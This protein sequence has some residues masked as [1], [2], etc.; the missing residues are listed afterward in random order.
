MM[1]RDCTAQVN[2]RSAGCITIVHWV[3]H[4]DAAYRKTCT[5]LET[6]AASSVPPLSFSVKESAAFMVLPIIFSNLGF[7]V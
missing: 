3:L 5:M 4:S 7:A 1:H 2:K 6:E